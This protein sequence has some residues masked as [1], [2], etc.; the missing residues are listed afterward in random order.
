M[1]HENKTRQHIAD[2]P[3]GVEVLVK[4]ASVDPEFR[5]LLLEKRGEAADEIGLELMEAER[6]ILSSIPVEQL[7]KIIDNTKVK[8]EHRN[9][10]RGKAVK[11][12]L[13]AAAS[14]AVVSLYSILS[15]SG[16]AWAGIS[17]D[18]VRKMQTEDSSDVNDVNE[19][20]EPDID[21]EGLEQSS[22][23]ADEQSD[24]DYDEPN[25]TDEEN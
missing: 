12:M 9:I 20:N 6:K 14:L 21:S 4:K 2:I 18:R 17:P 7:E 8:P 10:F 3:L 19:P 16:V 22:I 25:R 24:E 5:Q 11:L 23:S 15:P 13:G 1:E